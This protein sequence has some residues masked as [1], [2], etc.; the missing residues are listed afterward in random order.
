MYK[1]TKDIDNKYIVEEPQLDIFKPD[2]FLETDSNKLLN[3]VNE[4]YTNFEKSHPIKV[5]NKSQFNTPVNFKQ[6]KTSP[7][8]R[9]YT[10][11]EGFSPLFVRQF[12]ERFK[13]SNQNIIFDPFGG[14]GTTVVES[15]LLG[16]N[17]FSNDV[18]PLSNFIAK[19]KAEHYSKNDLIDLENEKQVITSHLFDNKKNPP[20][21]ET[22]AS[23]FTENT[24]DSIL[25]VQGYIDSIQ[26]EKVKNLNFIA[27]LTILE[28]ISTHRKDG[29]GVKR[30][31]KFKGD[32][33][34]V[35]IIELLISKIDLF[36]F[37]IKNTTFKN[38]SK[39]QNQS[40]FEK[41]TLPQKADL[42]ITSPPYANCF[43]YSK[44]YLVELWFGGFFKNKIDQKIFRESSIISH[45]HYKWEVRHQAFGHTLINKEIYDY[46]STLN[47]WDRKIPQML[48]GYFNDIGKVLFELSENLNKGA[49]VG[50]VVGNSVYGG[51]PIAT[52]VLLAE[53]G[54]KLGYDIVGIES[55]RTLTSS[56]QQQRKIR[57]QDKKF[58]RESLVIL[59][60]K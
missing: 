32:F 30:K 25:R 59:R 26:N 7:I 56:S 6:A 51:V 3:F 19:V 45:V 47:L 16:F 8:H 36:I 29:N 22:V 31:K 27:L 50:F 1:E 42:V 9:W 12:I 57:E 43:D 15:A 52:D 17:S 38:N 40:S 54:I 60:W 11:K 28:S 58:L 44:V 49:T 33:N 20:A 14:I 24:L 48:V 39:I 10:Y 23:Y 13:T 37:D 55:Y 53:T 18:N 21:N 5:I 34:I 41:Y 4:Y 2:K 35:Q 46:L